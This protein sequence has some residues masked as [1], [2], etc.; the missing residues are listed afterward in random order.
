MTGLETQWMNAFGLFSLDTG[1]AVTSMLVIF[2]ADSFSKE[3]KCAIKEIQVR[4]NPLVP[5][6][7][8][9]CGQKYKND[10]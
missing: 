3:G 4:R 1:V 9:S 8:A 10:I 5:I 6:C 7:D 2:E